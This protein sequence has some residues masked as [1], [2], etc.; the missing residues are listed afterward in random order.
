MIP[1]TLTKPVPSRARELGSGTGFLGGGDCCRSMPSEVMPAFLPFEDTKL[2]L[3]D[4]P[5]GVNKSGEEFG[6]SKLKTQ[7]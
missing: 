3:T 4:A 6:I 7:V 2:T 5:S 1:A